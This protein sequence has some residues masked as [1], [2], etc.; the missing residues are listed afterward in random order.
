MKMFWLIS[1]WIS[2]YLYSLILCNSAERVLLTIHHLL[3]W[4]SGSRA[5]AM[6]SCGGCGPGYATP[7][8]ARCSWCFGNGDLGRGG[9]GYATLPH[10]GA[11]GYFEMVIS[12]KL[13]K[14]V[15]D[16]PHPCESGTHAQD[17][18]K[19]VILVKVAKVVL[20]M[21]HQGESGAHGEICPSLPIVQSF[22]SH[23]EVRVP[24]YWQSYGGQGDG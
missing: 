2:I 9:P 12:M 14:V 18:F 7:R 1:K 15:L 20:A 8:W 3:L 17:V 4:I 24:W 21:P 22:N 13:A 11:Y 10:P 6:A 23:G 16:M 19:M 5:S